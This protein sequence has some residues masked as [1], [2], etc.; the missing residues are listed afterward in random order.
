MYM[1]YKF[2][3]YI[4][5]KSPKHDMVFS[6]KFFKENFYYGLGVQKN[7]DT[8]YKNCELYRV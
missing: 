8:K 3:V 1:T 5:K 4:F 2:G 6:P 7:A